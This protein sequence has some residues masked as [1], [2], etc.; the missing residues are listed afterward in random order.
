PGRMWRYAE[1]SRMLRHGMEALVFSIRVPE[2]A[3]S[4][5]LTTF[6]LKPGLTYD[7]LHD[8]MKRRDCIIYAGQGEIRTYDF[9]VSNMGTLT[10]ADM[11]GEST[12]SR[13]ACRGSS[14]GGDQRGSP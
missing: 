13:G 1:S 3:R 14:G 4:S 5:I 9:R 6:R 11:A 7:A 2:A 12:P 8:A 10:P